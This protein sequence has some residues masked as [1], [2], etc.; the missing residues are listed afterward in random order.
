VNCY[1]ISNGKHSMEEILRVED[2]PSYFTTLEK[3]RCIAAVDA[4]CDP[5]TKELSENYLRPKGIRSLL[6]APIRRG[7]E[8][9]GVIRYEQTGKYRNWT[10]EEQNFSASI[11]DL[12]TLALEGWS[13]KLAQEEL[14]MAKEAAE[15]ANRAKSSFLANMSHE[16]RTP[17]NAVIGYSEILQ[18]DA[19]LNGHKDLVPDLEKIHSAGKHLLDIISDILDLSKIEAGKIELALQ[20]FD[21]RDMLNELTST[22]APLVEKN[23]NIFEVSIPE[24]IGSMT[25]DKTRV[26]QI[27]FNLL[28]N[29]GKFTENG[30]II[31]SANRERTASS[32]WIRFN[33]SDSGIGMS[34]DQVANLFNDFSQGDA[35]T[36][37]KYGGTGL[38]LSISKRFCDLMGGQI[39]VQSELGAGSTFTV[40][41]PVVWKEKSEK[42]GDHPFT[43]GNMIKEFDSAL[44]SQS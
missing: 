25:A 40:H 44:F 2:Y 21:I 32:E 43:E 11:A 36:T 27:L 8:I 24:Q 6:D 31:V 17:L 22:I 23:I 29:A 9:A 34:P 15:A 20:E 4:L 16:I 7:G 35:S 10:L 39:S 26:R 38:G 19:E 1:E 13:R 12:A 37:R 41:L 5:R 28:S 18:E 42:S 14:R 30:H 33:I 3:E